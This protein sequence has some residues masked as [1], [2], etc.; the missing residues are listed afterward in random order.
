MIRSIHR[1]TVLRRAALATA[2]TALAA[3]G[4]GCAGDDEPPAT[5][6]PLTD[7]EAAMLANALFANLDGGG[8]EFAVAVQVGAGASINL[9]G[10]IDW[11]THRGLAQVS[12]REVEVGVRE[13]F[14]SDDAVL[15]AR[16]DLAPL[17]E[18]A[19]LVAT[20]WVV[21]DPDPVGR[22][23]DQVL[24]VV[25]GLAATQRDNPLLVAQEPGSAFLR[26]DTI[27]GVDAV[28]L[29]WGTRGT[30]WLAADDGRM[31]RFESDNATRTRPVVVDLL[32]VRAVTIDGPPAELV[33]DVA[34]IADVYAAAL[35]T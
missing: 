28:V 14:W 24:A 17:L 33:T 21:R 35:A 8:A 6:R 30:F 4:V 34:D 12:T 20:P 27:R 25:T 26:A 15:E 13:V 1:R 31:L 5:D 11:T 2:L 19:G 10:E 32:A 16:D 22:Q 23:L 3:L 18:Q 7:A 29:R 9:Q